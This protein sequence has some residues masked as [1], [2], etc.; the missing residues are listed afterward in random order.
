MHFHGAVDSARSARRALALG[1]GAT[2]F[3]MGLLVPILPSYAQS[4]GGTASLVG[5][6]IASFAVARLL[7]SL[8]AT[9]LAQRIGH[10]RLLIGTPA[11]MVPAAALCGFAGGFWTLAFFCVVEGAA[12][13][14]YATVSMSAIV[15]DAES[16]RRTRSLASYQSVALFGAALGPVVGGGL[17]QQFGERTPFFVYA[18]LAAIVTWWLSRRLYPHA[19]DES[20][21]SD[22][23]DQSPP[24][25]PF[26][27]LQTPGVITVSLI[28]FAVLFTRVGAQ[29]TLAPLLGA[30]QL[31]LS[32]GSIG[33]ALSLGGMA[34]VLVLYPAGLV[35]DRHGPLAVVLP[36]ALI[37]IIGLAAL[38][39]SQDLLSFMVAAV[40]LGVGSGAAGLAPATYLADLM[41]TRDR[42]L[43][44]GVYRTF[45]DSGAAVAPVLLGWMVDRTGYVAAIFVP[46]LVL[47][48]VMVNFALR[49]PRLVAATDSPADPSGARSEC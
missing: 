20:G 32:T 14:A 26:L 27:L 19:L 4:L 31:G 7:V 21:T 9:W 38:G 8:P 40:F 34:A 23:A 15:G 25:S 45:G 37:M 28:A 5:L 44:V 22:L 24:Q 6:L 46:A 2:A 35:A 30:W 48:L 42:P 1:T 33:F 11:I 16:N 10:R 12:A 29:L 36:G 47:G 17:A 18:A 41:S 49:S 13:G 43:G 3:G 39:L